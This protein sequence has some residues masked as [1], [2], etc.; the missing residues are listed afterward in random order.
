MRNLSKT[1]I[2]ALIAAVSASAPAL[3]ESQVKISG[4]LDLGVFKPFG[5]ETGVGQMSRSDITF[6][7]QEDLGGGLTAMF[8][9]KTRLSL[10]TGISADTPADVGKKPFFHGESTLGL[11]GS[12]GSV[13][14]GRALDVLG[15]NNWAYDPWYNFDSVASPAWNLWSWNYTTDRVSNN[16]NPEYGRLNSGIFYDSPSVNGVTAH[17]S[18]SFN[19]STAPGA[20]TGN[21]FGASLDYAKGPLSLMLGHTKNSSGDKDTFVGAKYTLGSLALM[22]AWDR[23]SYKGATTSTNTAYTLGAS[24]TMGSTRLMAGYGHLDNGLDFVGLGGQYFLSKRTNVY[25]SLG[26]KR[27]STGASQTAYGVGMNHSF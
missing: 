17:V 23:T 7:G 12:L 16:G 20:G 18:G 5:G 1:G 25:I 6:S 27:P 3:A 19:K 26:N 14:I 21:N 8:K 22:G 13:R 2:A 24:Y 15:N 4:T 11:K 10:A 9:L